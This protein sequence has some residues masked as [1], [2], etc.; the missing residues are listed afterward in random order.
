MERQILT[1]QDKLKLIKDNK[2]REIKDLG[3][4]LADMQNKVKVHAVRAEESE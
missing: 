4:K 3:R 2:D 1:A